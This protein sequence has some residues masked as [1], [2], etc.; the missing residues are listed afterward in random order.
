MG[1]SLDAIARFGEGRHCIKDN[2]LFFSSS[3]NSDPNHAQREL[4]ISCQEHKQIKR[5]FRFI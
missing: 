4:A 1:A 5:G 2:K 3:D